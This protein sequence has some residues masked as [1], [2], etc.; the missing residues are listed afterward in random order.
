MVIVEVSRKNQNEKEYII[1]LIFEVFIN[2]SYKIIYNNN[3]D[4]IIKFTKNKSSIEF[5]QDFFLADFNI[6]NLTIPSVKFVESFLFVKK[7]I[8]L[9]YGSEEIYFHNDSEARCSIDVFGAIF[10]FATRWEE[11]ISPERDIHG[12]FS[13]KNSLAYK[14]DYIHRQVLNEYFHF[15]FNL[16]NHLNF[17]V[18]LID[19]DFN[20]KLSHDIDDIKY[21]KFSKNLP[22]K[23]LRNDNI[24]S[25]FKKICLFFKSLFNYKYDPYNT[26]SQ[27]MNYSEDLNSKSMFFFMNGGLSNIYDN[28]YKFKSAKKIITKISKNGHHIGVHPSYH[29]SEN[30]TQLKSEINSFNNFFNVDSSRQHYLKIVFPDTLQNLESLGIK[31]D[32]TMGYHDLPGFRLGT[33][34]TIVAYNY[35]LRKKSK[36][37]LVPLI[38]MDTTIFRY[39]DYKNIENSIDSIVH[40]CKFHNTN[41]NILI[42]NN[43]IEYKSFNLF[44]DKISSIE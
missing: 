11:S 15:I 26:F 37:N 5:K 33:A 6:N 7:D 27:L 21:F 25:P 28:R 23:F 38:I 18:N 13:G 20:V 35:I 9:L 44:L 41:L 40:E 17:E 3:Y 32:Y 4:D 8:P 19:R 39:Y 14:N 10:F 36:I 24:G 2:S 43:Y 34:D 1:S 42:H 30:K 12:R 29:S 16:M 31:Y 22:K